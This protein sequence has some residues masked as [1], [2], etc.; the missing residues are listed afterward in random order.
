[1]LRPIPI[2]SNIHPGPRAQA[3]QLQLALPLWPGS[4]IDSELTIMAYK[5]SHVPALIACHSLRLPGTGFLVA[6]SLK[7]RDFQGEQTDSQAEAR[8]MGNRTNRTNNKK[9][10]KKPLQLGDAAQDSRMIHTRRQ[11]P[12]FTAGK[13]MFDDE[14]LRLVEVKESWS[15]FQEDDNKKD[16]PAQTVP[17]WCNYCHH[18]NCLSRVPFAYPINPWISRIQDTFR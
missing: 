5:S 13:L 16:R 4:R 3:C 2:I 14:E 9:T 11:W 12:A 15:M 7:F 10:P 8:Q 18:I 17:N 1:M 6:R